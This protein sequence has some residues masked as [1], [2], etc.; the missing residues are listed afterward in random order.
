MAMGNS[1]VSMSHNGTSDKSK[2]PWTGP[3]H[4]TGLIWHIMEK[5]S[6]GHS[7]ATVCCLGW[8]HVHATTYGVWPFETPY[9]RGPARARKKT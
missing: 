4:A 1:P 3:T 7:W 5:I 8:P 2:T 9:F 6:A